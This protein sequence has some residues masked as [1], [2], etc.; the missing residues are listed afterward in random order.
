[1][2]VLG[3]TMLTGCLDFTGKHAAEREDLHKRLKIL[4]DDFKKVA[5][6]F[7]HRDR[8]K[9]ELIITEHRLDLLRRAQKMMQ[10]GQNE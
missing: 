5:T 6:K 2:L 4:R 7:D 8:Y 1:M 3:G 9:Q 10:E